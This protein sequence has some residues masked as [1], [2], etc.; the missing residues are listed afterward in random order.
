MKRITKLFALVMSFAVFCSI[1]AYAVEPVNS[2][3]EAEDAFILV[4]GE[5]IGSL[6][7][8][9]GYS[10]QNAETRAAAATGLPFS[11]T[12]T[13]VTQ[14]LT[15]RESNKSFTGG[16]F[17]A[18]DDEGLLITGVLNQSVGNT[19]K[20]GACYYEAI[21]DTYYSVMPLYFESGQSIEAWIPKMSGRVMYFGN[22]TTYYGHI[23]NYSGT[24]YVSGNLNFSVSTS[25]W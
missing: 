5:P 21:D 8:D 17:D 3:C 25:P 23:T 12:A 13:H 4:K 10:S 24:G 14:L 6:A 20:A 2:N 22:S 7:D 11:M 1:N 16:A 18:L 19:V 9:E 15:T